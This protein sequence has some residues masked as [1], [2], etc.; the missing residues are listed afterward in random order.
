[1][2]YSDDSASRY[3]IERRRPTNGDFWQKMCGV[4]DETVRAKI[5]IVDPRSMN[6]NRQRRNTIGYIVIGTPFVMSTEK[7]LKT[8][9]ACVRVSRIN[10]GI[11]ASSADVGRTALL[12]D[13]FS[14]RLPIG[15]HCNFNCGTRAENATCH[16]PARNRTSTHGPKR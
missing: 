1:M 8:D 12:F 10:R 5:R 9:T 11:R 6:A 4:N 3:G 13:T 2:I 16:T 7:L 14:F 15:L